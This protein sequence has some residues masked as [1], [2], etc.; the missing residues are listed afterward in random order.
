MPYPSFDSRA[1]G[2]VVSHTVVDAIA[3][4]VGTASIE[5]MARD[6]TGLAASQTVMPG[7]MTVTIPSLS[8]DNEDAC[9]EA[10]RRLRAL[11][12]EPVP[13]LAARRF[14]SLEQVERLYQRLRDEADVRRLFFVGGEVPDAAGNFASALELLARTRPARFGFSHI[15]FG[16]YP[17]A[18]PTVP[19]EV[20]ER[21]LET[22]IAVTEDAGMSSFV[23]TQFAFAAEPILD[24]LSAFRTRFER[25]EVLIGLAGPA[26]IRT[27]IRY[28]RMCG[29]GPSARALVRN[30]AS[31]GRLLTD[32]G[33][34]SVIRSLVLA[35]VAGSFG[36]VRPHFFPF[37][38]LE[39]TAR[40]V[41][42]V[43]DGR[44]VLRSAE[45]GFRLDA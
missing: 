30:G 31:I 6:H 18:H 35:D 23:I 33:P 34:D 11:G 12:F 37:G 10:A 13:H 22:K 29:V 25:Q 5:A 8:G 14:V 39:R 24:W 36:P 16:A 42:A 2:T 40:W 28:A 4:L 44:I 19:T 9:V 20:L 26:G 45:S 3:G 21:E 7:G 43:A 17:E 15:G 32:T 1:L 27:L 38:G 41:S